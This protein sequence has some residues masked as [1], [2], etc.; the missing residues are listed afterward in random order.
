MVTGTSTVR[1]SPDSLSLEPAAVWHLPPRNVTLANGHA[2]ESQ[3]K[4]SQVSGEGYSARGANRSFEAAIQTAL[5]RLAGDQRCDQRARGF[6]GAL[7]ALGGVQDVVAKYD[8]NPRRALDLLE[9]LFERRATE[10]QNQPGP[11]A[12]AQQQRI[13]VGEH[14]AQRTLQALAGQWRMHYSPRDVFNLGAR[15][16]AK[17]GLMRDVAAAGHAFLPIPQ[18]DQ[19]AS[20]VAT[21]AAWGLQEFAGVVVPPLVVGAVATLVAGVAGW[22]KRSDA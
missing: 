8:Y 2:S 16:A 7:A 13:G 4:C 22:F 1:T 15:I 5:N 3:L 21:I 17:A 9:T 6:A 11:H 10:V 18:S 19:R 12:A 20:A 14:D